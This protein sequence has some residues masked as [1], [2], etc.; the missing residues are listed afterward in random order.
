MLLRGTGTVPVVFLPSLTLAAALLT[1]ATA[2]QVP[3]AQAVLHDL[4]L[5]QRVG[6]L[7][8]VGTT[9]DQV[10]RTTK[11]QIGSHHVGNVML[12]GRSYGG[13][14][15]PAKVSKVMRNQVS[16]ASTGGVRLFVATDQEGGLVRVLQ[17]PGFS[18]IPA[19]LEQGTWAPRKLRG[20]AHVWAKQLRSAGVNLDLAP[21]MD[22]VPSK[23]AA[24]HN[25]PIGKYHREFGYTTKVVARHGVA[26]LN[27]MADGG[28]ATSAKHFPGLGRVRG[29]TDTAAGVTDHVTR[30]HDPYFKP[31][32]AAVDAHVP[33]MMMSTAYY[34]HLDPKLPA[35]FSPY[36]IGTV[37]RGD[38]GFD[39]VVISDDL[40]GAQQVAG[41][42]PAGRALRFIGAGGDVVLT[43]HP[44]TLPAMYDAVLDRARA[45]KV[46]RAKVNAAALRVLT[47]KQHQHL[48]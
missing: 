36:V 5:A 44:D 29:N 30:R 35:A 22:T 8:M 42:T 17:G 48:L 24:K 11:A 1:G 3:P 41:F 12:T 25:P 13:V 23:K 40:G 6:Q 28:V 7:F 21:V 47:A 16:K 4:T 20:A 10:D 19:A 26:F 38:L 37:L 39:G 2:P 18:N 31:F 14:K 9:A 34:Q 45:S 15:K 33:F 32:Q 43:V 27:G 46:F